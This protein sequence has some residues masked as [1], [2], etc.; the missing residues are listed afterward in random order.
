L[1]R[2][3]VVVLIV[4][5]SSVFIL[6][7]S[8]DADS[9]FFPSTSIMAGDA[10]SHMVP[11][12][13]GETMNIQLAD[14]TSTLDLYMM[15]SVE[16]DELKKNGSAWL[17]IEWE[18]KGVINGNWDHKIRRDGLWSLVVH[19]THNQTITY[20]L[21]VQNKSFNEDV[22]DAFVGSIWCCFGIVVVSVVGVV[23]LVILFRPRGRR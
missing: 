15:E 21:L 8:D 14:A 23:V 10:K 1:K 3:C 11:G 5:F 4:L 2:F 19:N 7:F 9:Q 16:I 12:G 18:M 17:D 13:V 6:S 20:K 22:K